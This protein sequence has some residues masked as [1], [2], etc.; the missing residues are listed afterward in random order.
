MHVLFRSMRSLAMAL[1]LCAGVGSVAQP[2]VALGQDA[3]KPTTLELA[4]GKMTLET[5]EGW[6]KIQPSINMIQYEFQVPHDADEKQRARVT[7]MAAGGSIEQN[8]DRWKGQF[9]D[10]KDSNVKV[11]KMEVAGQTVHY[12]DITGTFKQTSGGPFAP[13][14]TT[15]IPNYRMLGLIIATKE[16]G[17]HFLKM[18]G[19]ND[20]VEKQVDGLKKMAQSLKVK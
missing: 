5:P 2:T 12:V 14:P 3:P 19:P 9:D 13:G 4:G 16:M 8:I 1:A 15:K 10:V 7:L 11:E 20:T 6:K 17:T 18:T